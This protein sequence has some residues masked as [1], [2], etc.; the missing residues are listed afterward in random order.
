MVLFPDP[1]TFSLV[2]MESGVVDLGEDGELVDELSEVELDDVEL[3]EVELDD[4]L[5]DVELLI[6]AVVTVDV[7]DADDLVDC[8]VDV[9][10]IVDAGGLADNKVDVG[11]VVCGLNIEE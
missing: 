3:D 6:A 7:D 11:R 1:V 2:W 8:V 10:V 4:E 9:D 5:D